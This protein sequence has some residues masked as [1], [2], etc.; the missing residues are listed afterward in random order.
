MTATD[1]PIVVT[2]KCVTL[3]PISDMQ[4]NIDIENIQWTSL[5]LN[6]LRNDS[7]IS[8]DAHT[9]LQL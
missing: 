1:S 9:D 4:D 2:Q 7:A 6:L 5:Q 3:T 8:A